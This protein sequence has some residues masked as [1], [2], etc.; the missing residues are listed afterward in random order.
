MELVGWPLFRS[1][2]WSWWG[3]LF[4]SW[5]WRWWGGLFSEAGGGVGRVASFLKLEVEFVG[6]PLFRNWRW[7]WWGGLFRSFRALSVVILEYPD[8]SKERLWI[9]DANVRYLSRK[10]IPFFV[11]AI[12]ILVAGL[13]Y[14]LL[15]LLWQWLL[16]LPQWKIF[17]W[18]RNPKLKTFIETCH[19]CTL[20]S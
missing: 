15:L 16:C 8:G 11:V 14:T 3:G 9:P 6:W 12:L 17:A 10:H 13:S 5:R 20:L 7:S 1:W 19:A 4:R 18:T 2:S